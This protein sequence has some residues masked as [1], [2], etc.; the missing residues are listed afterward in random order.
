MDPLIIALINKQPAFDPDWSDVAK[1]AWWENFIRMFDYLIC[2]KAG[3][4][5]RP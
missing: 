1:A 3:G 5:A 2:R 4:E